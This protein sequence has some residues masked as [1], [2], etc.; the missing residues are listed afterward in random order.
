MTHSKTE[1]Q[2]ISQMLKSSKNG[3]I[4]PG[5]SGMIAKRRAM[6]AFAVQQ[7]WGKDLERIVKG[8]NNV[9]PASQD[10]NNVRKLI[11]CTWKDF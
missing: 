1:Q 7:W 4:C 10:G 9:E 8:Q 11:A 5:K 2:I 3:E 6:Y